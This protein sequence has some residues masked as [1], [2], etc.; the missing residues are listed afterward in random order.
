MPQLKSAFAYIIGMLDFASFG[1]I[2]S[3][4]QRVLL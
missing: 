1:S 4:G 3:G 2:T